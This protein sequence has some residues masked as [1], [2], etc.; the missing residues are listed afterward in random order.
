MIGSDSAAPNVSIVS[1]SNGL[2]LVH[3]NIQIRPHTVGGLIDLSEPMPA[4][5]RLE[6]SYFV[7]YRISN[8]SMKM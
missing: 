4:Q 3:P 7:Y 2:Q 8:M 6:T 5:K 1:P